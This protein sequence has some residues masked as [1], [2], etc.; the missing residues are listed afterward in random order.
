[1]IK[2]T[3]GM[4]LKKNKRIVIAY[5][6]EDSGSEPGVGYYWAKS[7]SEI[8]KDEEV[9]VLTRKNNNIIAL[10]ERD[11]LSKIGLDLSEPLL[12]I[13]KIIGIRVYYF[14]WTMLV[15]FHLIINYKKYRNSKV[16]HITFTP[17][18]YPPLYF[19]L[20]YDFIWGPVGGG[21]TY[22]LS[23]LKNMR[24]I[25]KITELLRIVIK[26]SVY[27]NPLFYLACINSSKIICSTPD[28]ANIVPFF[29]N[30][31]LHVEL[32]VFDK[33]KIN[34]NTDVKKDIVIAN[35]LIHWKMTL[36]FVEAFYI[37]N[38][39][40]KS[41]YRLVIIGDGPCFDQIKS[42]IDDSKII[43]IAR[44]DKREDM[45]NVLKQSS[46]F[47]SMSLRDSGAA[48]LLEAVSYGIPFLVTNSGAHNVFLEQDIGYGF[49][50]KSYDE[51]TA[52][53]TYMLKK[54]LND[55]AVLTEN[56]GKVSN[57]YKNYFCE[58][59]KIKRIKKILDC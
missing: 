15:F 1:M 12:K 31:K 30:E 54:I 53:I 20:P 36:L 5:A 43:H 7:I 9:L 27:I 52:K 4:F 23:Y 2:N 42:F 26:F 48:S 16:H 44:F 39:K 18:Y 10:E 56:R 50:L 24:G 38:L 19:I 59:E 41:D 45:L 37:Y 49:D 32:M 47:V 58:D 34:T 46:L 28:T 8:Y 14:I 6:C 22:P 29:F 51:D 55:H 13:K 17:I 25:D 3:G 11:N 33:D 40:Y 21:E 57:V 35:R